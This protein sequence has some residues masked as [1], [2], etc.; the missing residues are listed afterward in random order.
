MHAAGDCAADDF[1]EDTSLMRLP[2]RCLIYLPCG[3]PQPLSKPIPEMLLL[4][5]D[6]A[7]DWLHRG[8]IGAQMTAPTTLPTARQ[9][10][11]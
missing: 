11:I 1:T 6:D 9:L 7:G 8:D 4:I 3:L 2:T 10:G 5:G